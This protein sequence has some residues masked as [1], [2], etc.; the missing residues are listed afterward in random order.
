MQHQSGMNPL[1]LQMFPELINIYEWVGC[2]TTDYMYSQRFPLTLWIIYHNVRGNIL[3]TNRIAA[4]VMQNH[5][6]STCHNDGGNILV[7]NHV[8]AVIMTE[9]TLL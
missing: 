1:Y 2:P 6:A 9:E 3:V 7:T 8:A 5:S 4:V